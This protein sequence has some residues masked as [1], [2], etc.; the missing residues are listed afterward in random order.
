MKK[1]SLVFLTVYC[2]AVYSS[3]NPGVINEVKR[4][5]PS[6]AGHPL[7]Q[8]LAED[9][10]LEEGA[11]NTA[12]FQRLLANW[13]QPGYLEGLTGLIKDP[14]PAGES[15]PL[16]TVSSFQDEGIF[17]HIQNPH[18]VVVAPDNR[19]WVLPYA[20]TETID[21][22]ANQDG[23]PDFSASC[24]AIYCYDTNG[25][26]A[27][28]SPIKV[29]NYMG[30]LDTL[31]G[32]N[33]GLSLGNDGSLLVSRYD[34]F[35]RLDYK[36]GNCTGWIDLSEFG[37]PTEAAC[38]DQGNIY[39]GALNSGFPIK[40][41]NKDLQYIGNVQDNV[42]YVSRSLV[43]TPDGKELYSGAIY[44]GINGVYHYHSDNGPAGPYQ[45]DRILGTDGSYSLWA[46]CLDWGPDGNIW[47][48]TYWNVGAGDPNG[49]YSLDPV[50]GLIVDSL[51][52]N[53]RGNFGNFP[54]PPPDNYIYAP[55]GLSW[56]NDSKVVYTADFDA[57]VIK[58]WRYMP[59]AQIYLPE[60]SYDFQQVEI[61]MTKSWGLQIINRGKNALI[62]SDISGNSSAFSI[63]DTYE[64]IAAGDTFTAVVSFT[65]A[66]VG[67]FS[68]T[69]SVQS[70]D[71]LQPE[72]KVA[73]QGE[74][75]LP[76]DISVRP[77]SLSDSLVTS[78]VSRHSIMIE[79]T[80]AG[81]LDWS[82]AAA[83]RVPG[84]TLAASPA[85]HTPSSVTNNYDLSANFSGENLYLFNDF[86]NTTGRLLNEETD[87]QI[88]E[89][90]N[91]PPSIEEVLQNLNLYYQSITGIIPNRY[92]FSGG[93]TGYYISD[94][95]NNMYSYGNQIYTS[96][97][98]VQ[99][100][101]NVISSDYVTGSSGR[102]FT[103]KYPGLFVFTADLN[104][105][106][107]FQIDG[108]L[109]TGGNGTVDGAV[110]QTEYFGITY[111][112]FVKRVYDGFTPSVNHLIIVPENAS[113][114]HEFPTYSYYDNHRVY[115][116]EGINR[117]YYLLF[118]GQQGYYME[119]D[120]LL[121]MMSAFL[122]AAEARPPWISVQPESG[123][124]SP[125]STS[126]VSIEFDA[127]S[128][129]GGDYLANLLIMSNDPIKPVVKVPVALHI[130]GAPNIKPDP[131]Q[132]DFGEVF[133]SDTSTLE[134]VVK[135]DGTE[136]LLIF[137]TSTEPEE[138]SVR[139]MYAGVDVGDT[140]LFT[141]QFLPRAVTEY[142]GTLVLKS[143]DPDQPE[144][145][146]GLSGKGVEPPMISIT[147]DSLYAALFTNDIDSQAVTIQN[148]G[149]SG[150][151]FT[152]EYTDP[153]LPNISFPAG[154]SPSGLMPAGFV[155]ISDLQIPVITHPALNKPSSSQ[156]SS[157]SPHYIWK[158]LQ[159]DPDE[160]E[161]EHDVKA[162]YGCRSGGQILFRIVG[163]TPWS[164]GEYDESVC[165][166]FIDADK[167]PDTGEKYFGEE[168][169]LELGADYYIFRDGYWGEI[170]YWN[171]EFQV[172]DFLDT[173]STRLLEKNELI[174][175]IKESYLSDYKSV[176]LVLQAGSF[177]ES[178]LDLVPDM[179]QSVINFPLN[180]SWLRFSIDQGEVPADSALNFMVTFDATDLFG[181]DYKGQLTFKSN[182]PVTPELQLPVQVTVTGIP[183]YFCASDTLDFVSTFAGFQDSISLVIENR[184]T[185]TLKIY[186]VTPADKQVSASQ[187]NLSVAP[188]SLDSLSL[189]LNTLV[190]GKFESEIS[191][192]TNDSRYPQVSLPVTSQVIKAP[193]I[194]VFPASISDSIMQGK[195]VTHQLIL[196]NEGYSDLIFEIISESETTKLL[197]S[198]N[199][200]FQL[201]NMLS[202]N[203]QANLQKPADP[204]I[205]SATSAGKAIT[206]E[207]DINSAT[208]KAPQVL[209]VCDEGQYGVSAPLTALIST[210]LFSGNDIYVLPDPYNMSTSDFEPYDVVLVWSN[211][212]FPDPFKLGNLLRN[213][214]DQGGGV[215]LAMNL[216]NLYMGLEGSITEAYYT[217]FLPAAPQTVSGEID[218]S[219]LAQPDHPVF[220]GISSNLKYSS[221][222]Q[223][224]SPVLNTGGILLASDTEG[225]H[226]VAENRAGNIVGIAINPRLIT[227]TATNLETRR[228][229]ANALYYVW[230]DNW[231]DIGIKKG[232]ISAGDSSVV[233]ITLNTTYLKGEGLHA[234][235]VILSNDPDEN[236]LHI[237][238]IL[239]IP[240]AIFSP[241]DPALPVN[242]EL[243]QNYPNPFNPHTRIKFALPQAG[244]IKLEMFN[245]LGQR[246]VV[247]VDGFRQAGYHEITFDGSRFA[248]GVYYYRLSTASFTSVKK[249][250]LIK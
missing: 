63:N 240:T 45:L 149:G 135:N 37:S 144:Y 102:Y 171:E 66:T 60:I 57:H 213:F 89:S 201:T 71:T 47:I 51:G 175:G 62:V 87:L 46:Q 123:Q 64:E 180:P 134:L 105:I 35:Y 148:T 146:V 9:G 161:L 174:I 96:N 88:S 166:I 221:D 20:S 95:G 67:L 191:F 147:P 106:S 115:N 128:L 120:V 202:I 61:G 194:T 17:L 5:D 103:R 4:T 158:L 179:N 125:G 116:L 73:V 196:K 99:Y 54:L 77:D 74:G 226:V 195:T 84:K 124:T 36:T 100:S 224:A 210:G 228:L 19:I 65:P 183:V 76:P 223:S 117:L 75:W 151:N 173:L 212:Y 101:N 215:V 29:I 50:S 169:G 12:I 153:V 219:R 86:R 150:L 42:P 157:T 245:L 152:V 164:E 112:G 21:V 176:N 184:G 159:T 197:K 211:Y 192:A 26:Q 90:T 127:A 109:G 119:N 83:Y 167:D 27:D 93:E 177:N 23:T 236:I 163:Y 32:S 72:I 154:K 220:R 160:P 69:L 104:N 110:L 190:T 7:Y 10:I 187:V 114:T 207:P 136:D 137:S 205:N 214:V 28:F 8:R 232:I 25:A 113:A 209:L 218:F 121:D 31:W 155:R 34:N 141:V 38:D 53:L 222:Y 234:N 94:G 11:D 97:G 204:I 143:N 200:D 165:W 242:Y 91:T 140:Q 199:S 92:D 193:D 249:M 243:S 15:Y 78:A 58:K 233:D 39:V 235:L 52:T 203:N 44:T 2:I 122:H 16:N 248:S 108:Y 118:A 70:S 230:K 182:D 68:D 131:V 14:K 79:N 40:I 33:R 130:T 59:P 98:Q 237:P 22:D 30:R 133:V 80:G 6:I 129:Y 198:S 231:V 55:R 227:N 82:V 189:Y 250:V 107:S 216:Y 229:F 246:T 239:D 132:L 156:T 241:A 49:W 186:G 139:P 178:Y 1:T 244:D 185:D 56:Q 81:Y 138:F 24:R 206:E 126:E 181:G 111:Y 208:P 43:V 85:F 48:G 188:M 3:D 168:Y 172:F 247:L 170:G 225:N 217:P 162:V 238:V 145:T 142:E 13:E 41:F 18:G